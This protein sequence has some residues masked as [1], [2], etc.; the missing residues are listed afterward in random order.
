MTANQAT[1]TAEPVGIAAEPPRFSGPQAI[2]NELT[3]A[4]TEAFL[5]GATDTGSA[6]RRASSRNMRPT[7][8]TT[9]LRS[10]CRPFCIG[11][12]SRLASG[13]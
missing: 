10:Y 5:T 7:T 2:T 4:R 13:K 8:A 9:T 3:D 1:A 6:T 11:A 12:T